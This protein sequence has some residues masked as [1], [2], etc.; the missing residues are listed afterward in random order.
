[1]SDLLRNTFKAALAERRLQR[2]IWCTIRDPL[3]AEMLAGCGFD[4]L[5][6]DTEHSPMDPVSVLPMLQAVA[7]YPVSP[8]VRPG[9][10]NAAEIKKLLDIGA[11]TILVPMVQNADEAAQ[12]VAAVW[13]LRHVTG[14]VAVDFEKAD[15]V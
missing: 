15:D 2:G 5:M 9:S 10:L 14:K 1:M 13:H 4:W 3:V 7:P 8:I 11:Q 6:F 12:A